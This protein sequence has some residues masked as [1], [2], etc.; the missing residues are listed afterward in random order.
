MSALLAPGVKY[1]MIAKEANGSTADQD[2]RLC[3]I[4][5]AL[6]GLPIAGTSFRAYLTK[7]LRELGYQPCKADPDVHMREEVW[8]DGTR[9]W[10]LLIA[11]VDDILCSGME[12]QQQLESIEKEFTLK[13][14]TIEEPYLYLGADIGKHQLPDGT[15]SWSMASSKYTAKAIATVELELGTERFGFKCLPKGKKTPISTEYR[16]EIDAT[17]ELNVEDQ[18]YYQGL[19]GILRWICEF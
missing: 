14:G 9:Y 18:N 11:Y 6:Y 16:P 7:H 13:D 3:I 8:K 15:M 5:R 17:E 19:V 4:V 12:P 10:A 2:G 1:Y